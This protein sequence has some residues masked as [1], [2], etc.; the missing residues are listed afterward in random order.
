[1]WRLFLVGIGLGPTQ[2][3][4]NMVSQSAAP[5]RQIGVAT[6]TSMFLRQC[7]GMIG[8]SLFGAM[9]TSKMAQ[10]I[11]KQFPGVN[12]DIGEMQKNGGDGR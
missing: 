10:S 4:F 9:L 3:L 2:S 5:M 6:S 8:V 11:A 1:V 12:V 7:G